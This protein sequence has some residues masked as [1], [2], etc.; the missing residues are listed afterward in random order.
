MIATTQ[1]KRMSVHSAAAMSEAPS[2]SSAVPTVWTHLPGGVVD[3]GEIVLLAIRPSMWRS[4][5]D[6]APWLVTMV[7][8]A[9]TLTVLNTQIPGLSPIMTAQVIL[10][11][12]VARLLLA[13]L[14]WVPTWYVLTN[15]RIIDMHGVREPRIWS[16]P[17][18]NVRNTYLQATAAE[19]MAKLGT[20]T[21][22]L[23][24]PGEGPRHWQSVGRPEEIHAA[25]RRAI[26]NAIDQQGM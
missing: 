5:F 1:P 4:L 20:L 24:N 22:V 21:F 18:L 12:G 25:I 19:R 23:D 6:S 13:I 10:F 14:R 7:L 3:G 26:E 16:C 8:L 11:V 9:G 2:R 15:R 17:L